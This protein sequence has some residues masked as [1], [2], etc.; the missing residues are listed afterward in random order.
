MHCAH[1]Q[2]YCVYYVVL[3]NSHEDILGYISGHAVLGEDTIRVEQKCIRFFRLSSSESSAFQ[4]Y[5]HKITI[6][7]INLLCVEK[8]VREYVILFQVDSI[9]IEYYILGYISGHAVLGED[10]I[11]VEQKCIRFFRL[12]SS[13]SSAFQVYNH[14]ITIYQ[15]NLLCVEKNGT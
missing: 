5:N 3:I 13:E 8:M 10:T 14:K 15:I 11:T 9:Y 7:Q 12:S 4:V 6:Y 2:R 1:S